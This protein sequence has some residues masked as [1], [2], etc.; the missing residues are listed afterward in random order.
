MGVAA[1]QAG[2]YEVAVALIGAAIRCNPQSADYRNNLAHTYLLQGKLPEAIDSYR[3]VLALDPSD[4]DAMH[5]L[6]NA[7]A[8][9][10]NWAEA[11]HWFERLLHLRPKWAE[12]HYH[13]GNARHGSGEL[14]A[15]VAGYRA[16]IQLNPGRPEF[17][18]NLAHTLRELG[19]LPE[20]AESYRRV[21]ALAPAD[22]EAHY[23]LGV[24]LH[25]MGQWQ[26][27]IDAYTQALRLKPRYPEAWSNLGCAYEEC[28]ELE[29]A[30]AAQQRALALNAERADTHN[31]LGA[32][33]F[34]LGD[35]A[36]ARACFDRA[37]ELQ[38][39]H[40][41]ARC[42]LGY[43]LSQQG[44][45]QGAQECYRRAIECDPGSATAHF[46]LGLTELL[47]GN[48]SVGWR[49][50]EFRWDTKEFRGRKR[51]LPVPQWRGEPLDHARILLHAEQG[52]GDTLQFVRY[53]PLVAARGG[54]VVLEVPGRLYRFL[55]GVSGVSEI[56]LRGE[57]LPEVDWQSPLMSLPLAFGTDVASIP[58]SIPYLSPDPAM[59][60]VWA[61]RLKPG[62]R[63]GLAWA[64]NPKHIRERQRSI[65][66][67]RLASLLALEGATFYSLQKG[68]ASEQCRDLPPGLNLIDLDAEQQDF[69]DTAAIVANLD[70]VISIDTAVAHLAGAMGKPVW[71][72]LHRVPDWRWLLGRND[73]PWYP[74][75]R[76]FR[77][78][79]AGVWDDVIEQLQAELATLIAGWKQQASAR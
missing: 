67:A 46:Y 4:S 11:I 69:A 30:I 62:L 15:A 68:P 79:F 77:Q 78:A 26:A 55:R 7:L 71:V 24:V 27:A 33:L 28:G 38:P 72:L 39:A 47:L 43:Q 45:L 19:A 18:F 60:E 36:G 1:Q 41:M 74:T 3:R 59:A 44:D 50:Y 48:Y 13:L 73:S 2:K 9:Q 52:L 65:P 75:A 57:P 10:G 63:V 76:L 35:E 20:A 21:V 56:V 29:A 37:L 34:R 64:G 25:E 66:L 53:V 42:N 32:A 12:A 14:S 70:L 31:N 54:Q 51:A 23:S 8:Q 40:V 16:A 5:S 49:E 61:G 58:A 22:A 17:H 6:A